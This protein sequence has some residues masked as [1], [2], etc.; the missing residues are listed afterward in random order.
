M[1]RVRTRFAPSPTGSM[2]LGNVRIAIFNWL[3]A[4]RHGGDFIV[5][6]EDTDIERNL[7]G[8][9][10]G[11]LEDLRWLGLDWD[12]GPGMEDPRGPYRQSERETLYS[13]AAR[14]LVAKQK[15][16]PCFCDDAD[17]GGEADGAVRFSCGCRMLGAEE[18][19]A[20]EAE[21]KV[22][23]SP[24]VLRF[25][26]PDGPIEVVDEVRGVVEFP[27]E[28]FGD[29]VIVRGDGRPTYN[30][31]VVVDDI[32][33]EVSHVL[34]GVGH[35]SNTPKQ[36]I[37]FD[38]FGHARPSFAHLP[39]VLGPDRKKLSK[40]EGSAAVSELRAEGFHPAG[41]VNYLS[42]LGWSAGG[43]EEILPVDELVRR[44]SLDRIGSS[45]TMYDPEKLRWASA[46]H[47]AR[48]ELGDVVEAVLPW[49]D[50]ERYPFG[51]EQLSTAIAAIRTHL[52]TF[53]EIN[54]HL[55]PFYPAS[56]DALEAAREEV[57]ADSEARRV[58]QAVRDRLAII[59]QW[60]EETLVAAVREAGKQEGA[61]GP[62]LFHPVRKGLSGESSGPEL[63]KVLFALGRAEVL[64]RLDATLG[65]T[66][67]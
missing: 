44:I 17:A 5:R 56:S 13:A 39:T 19:A 27:A 43:D 58:L 51:D 20:R 24:P 14:Q 52:S 7:P 36:A 60:Q 22:E 59:E 16:Y 54:A 23:G 61:R 8:A 38:A 32:A 15:A 1:T 35:L 45:D 57:R 34:R 31:A 42:L 10:E 47:I 12:E 50:R 49:L 26:V 2:H 66:G 30:F 62:A 21:A 25:A 65:P 41:I 3:F 55:A 11:I 64:L 6:M 29:F 33:M 40:R 53:S 9:E 37:L 18:R 63:G 46:Q 28:D 48:M 67:V 4:R